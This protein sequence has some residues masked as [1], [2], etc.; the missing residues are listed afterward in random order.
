VPNLNEYFIH[1]EDV[2][3]ANGLVHRALEPAMDDALWANV[4][5]G[6]RFLARRV[7]GAGLDVHRGSGSAPM[8]RARRGDPVVHLS[9]DP[10]ELLLFLFG[11]Q[12]V[13]DVELTGP[14]A[15]ITA[16]RGAHLGM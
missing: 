6:A 1:H 10:G 14:A 13:A 11:R 8:V 7:S 9:G 16:V 3:R 4:R 5:G 15:A 2:R 12:A